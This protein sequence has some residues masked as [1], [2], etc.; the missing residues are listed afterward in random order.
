[1]VL[2]P[3]SSLDCPSDDPPFISIHS[4]SFPN[5]Y[6]D[7]F[8]SYTFLSFI[9]HHLVH[10]DSMCYWTLFIEHGVVWRHKELYN[11]NNPEHEVKNISC[12]FMF[13]LII[14]ASLWSV[15]LTLILS[16]NSWMS[17]SGCCLPSNKEFVFGKHLSSMQQPKYSEKESFSSTRC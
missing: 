6:S 1:V 7:V 2:Q 8:P 5:A 14:V 11:C 10:G 16:E 9:L 15:Q 4:H 13:V 17:A 12:F 3:S